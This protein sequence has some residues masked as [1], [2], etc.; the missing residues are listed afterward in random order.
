MQ[1]ITRVSSDN[2]RMAR[3]IWQTVSTAW[4]E[5]ELR[6]GGLV[7]KPVLR[8]ISQF[9]GVCTPYMTSRCTFNSHSLRAGF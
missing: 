5:D 4:A 9:T 8:V 1:N 2:G 3:F 6:G 7:T